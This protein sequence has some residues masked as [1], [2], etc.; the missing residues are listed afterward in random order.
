MKISNV[1]VRVLLVL[2]L[3]GSAVCSFFGYALSKTVLQ[4]AGYI[5]TAVNAVVIVATEIFSAYKRAKENGESFGI[6]EFTKVLYNCIPV[7]VGYAESLDVTSGGQIKGNA[8]ANAVLDQLRLMCDKEQVNF[9]EE[10]ARAVIKPI[11]ESEKIMEK[12]KNGTLTFGEISEMVSCLKGESIENSQK[13]NAPAAEELE[14][15][16]QE[17]AALIENK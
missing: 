15:M 7:L 8:K 9:Y 14:K 13:C 11:I 6:G 16:N 2:A 10:Q 4:Y 1:I 5:L 12:V 3:L 17:L